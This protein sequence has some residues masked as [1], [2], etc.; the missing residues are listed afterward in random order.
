MAFSTRPAVGA[1]VRLSEEGYNTLPKL[2]REEMREALDV[3]TITSVG[4]EVCPG[5]WDIDLDGLLSVYLFST[6]DV[7][8]I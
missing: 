3:R 7:Y 6:E 2:T 1:R 8:P 4:D 5:V